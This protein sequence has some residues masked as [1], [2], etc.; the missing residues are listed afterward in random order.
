MTRCQPGLA[1]PASASTSTRPTAAHPPQ[2]QSLAPYT[3]A[4]LVPR[5]HPAA[6]EPAADTFSVGGVDYTLVGGRAVHVAVIVH[7]GSAVAVLTV[8]FC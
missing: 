7:R 5:R 3:P 8:T 1:H 6:G 4:G 2:G